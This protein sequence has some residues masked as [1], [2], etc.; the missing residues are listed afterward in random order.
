[1]NT[2]SSICRPFSP[3]E[4]QL[5]AC[6][7][8]ADKL[9]VGIAIIDSHGCI[10]FWNQWLKEKS[11]LCCDEASDNDFLTIFPELKNSRLAQVISDAIKHGLPSL[12]SQSL[13][14][15]PLPLYENLADRSQRVQQTIYVTPLEFQDEER[16]CLIQV[17]DVSIAVKKER[18]LREQAE[19]LRD[20]AF[21][22][23]LTGVANRRKL[24]EYLADEFKR[25]ARSNSPISVIMADVDNF[26]QFNDFYGHS[27]GDFCLQR[28]ANAIK[29]I[30]NRPADLVARYGGEEFVIVLP[31]T[32]S[33]GASVLAE[34]IRSHV[35]SL[36][37]PHESSSLGS[38]VTLSL[39]VSNAQTYVNTSVNKLLNQADQA[40]YQAKTK[41]RNQVVTFQE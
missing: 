10:F 8:A 4:L 23:S 24:D 1:M 26:K 29:A 3:T 7:A 6:T 38:H 33:G 39:G 11:G 22:D 13:N 40:L 17:N 41:G 9:N 36:A 16:F 25:A 18:L 5:K 14:K 31:D 2:L 15:S 35:E 28:V 30:L 34:E 20:F 12:L 32:S 19:I 27:N 21:I 37:I